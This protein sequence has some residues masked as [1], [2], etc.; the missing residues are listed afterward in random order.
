MAD[1]VTLPGTG[2]VVRADEIAAVQWQ[3][4]KLAFGTDGTATIVDASNP[5]PVRA[6]TTATGTLTN[7]TGIATS[8]TLLAANTA[9][10]GATI[11]NDSTAALYVKFGITASTTSY[12]V[13]IAVDGYYEVPFGYTGRID[14]IWASAAGA[15]R[16]TELSV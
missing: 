16:I 8:T 9:R 14:G 5:M 13:K 4:V 2:V 10:L 11:H 6:G 15:A 1:N 12:S 3:Y 7:V